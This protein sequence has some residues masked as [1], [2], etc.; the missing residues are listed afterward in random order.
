VE[1][2]VWQPHWQLFSWQWHAFFWQPQEQVSQPQAQLDFAVFFRVGFFTLD[3][4]F[5]LFS[6]LRVSFCRSAL[7]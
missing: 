4:V 7:S 2:A 6:F 3:I 1:A 5:L